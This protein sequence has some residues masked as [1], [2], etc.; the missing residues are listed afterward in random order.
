MMFHWLI[1]FLNII[2]VL[3]LGIVTL[4]LL[5]ESIITDRVIRSSPSKRAELFLRVSKDS[6]PFLK[7]PLEK[8]HYLI[9]RGTECD[10]LLKG[11][12]IPLRIG[13]IYLHDGNYFFRNLHDNSVLVNEEPIG[14]GAIKLLLG[15]EIGFHNYM[16]KVTE[17]TKA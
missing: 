11:M 7:I 17:N 16:I 8:S 9:G 4:W 2:V 15:D 3:F 13:K 1:K 12:G 10:I 5:Y 14:K 6:A